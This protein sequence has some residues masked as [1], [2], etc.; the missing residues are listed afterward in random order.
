V[1]PLQARD[2]RLVHPEQFGEARLHQPVP[3]AVCR[4]EQGY[5]V[6]HGGSFELRRDLVVVGD[7]WSATVPVGRCSRPSG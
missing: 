5:L 4:E 1:R 6:G 7:N 3:D 2:R